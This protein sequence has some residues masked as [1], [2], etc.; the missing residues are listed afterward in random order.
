[1]HRQR[2]AAGPAFRPPAA[3]PV[4]V[5]ATS[6]DLASD[7]AGFSLV[8]VVVA[9]GL[10]VVVSTAG[11]LALGTSIK[12]AEANENRVIAAG[13]ATAQIEQARAAVDP[14]ALVPGSTAVTRN[15]TTFQVTRQLAPPTGCTPAGTRTI[16]IT[17]AW[18]GTGGPVHSDTVRAC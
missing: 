1:M 13:L 18:P 6:E 9:L 15:G 12:H 17:I 7:D 4:G 3:G 11:A 2:C 8:E 14:S 5:P 16:T 10:L